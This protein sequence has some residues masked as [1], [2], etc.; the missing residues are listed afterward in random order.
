MLKLYFH[1]YSTFTRRISIYLKERGMEYKEEFVDMARLA[2]KKKAYLAL[3]PY[4]K[5]PLIEDGELLLYESAAILTYLE[6]KHGTSA[7]SFDTSSR[8]PT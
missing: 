3:N 6:H 2:H 7:L 4:G 1:P 5:L 8:L